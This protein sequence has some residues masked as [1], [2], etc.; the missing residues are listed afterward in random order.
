MTAVQIERDV[1]VRRLARAG[2]AARVPNGGS[3]KFD[4]L[5]SP[6]KVIKSATDL[7]IHLLAVAERV[8]AL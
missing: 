1:A 4:W 7:Q 8:A 5:R 3:L 6:Y 2:T